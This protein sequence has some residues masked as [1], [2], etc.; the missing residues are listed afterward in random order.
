M[1]EGGKG[2]FSEPFV[3]DSFIPLLCRKVENLASN[4]RTS[5]GCLLLTPRIWVS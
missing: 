1:G 2:W 3:L 4:F 5:F